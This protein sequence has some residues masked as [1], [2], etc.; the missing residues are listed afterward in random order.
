MCLETSTDIVGIG[1]VYDSNDPGETSEGIDVIGITWLSGGTC[2]FTL[3]HARDLYT[4]H[5]IDLNALNL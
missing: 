1:I 5:Q 4:L 2:N 3:A